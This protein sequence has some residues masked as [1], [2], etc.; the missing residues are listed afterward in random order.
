[1][2]PCIA[3]VGRPNV[4]K[5]TLFN[6]LIKR[7]KAIVADTPGVTRDRIFADARW[8]DREFLLVDTGGLVMTGENGLQI[9]IARQSRQAI[10]EA[11]M[12]IFLLDGKSGVTPDDARL[13]DYLR[14]TTKKVFWVVNKVESGADQVNSYD[15]YQLGM[16]KLFTVSAAHGLGIG[17][18]LDEI[19]AAL[20]SAPPAAADE[21]RQPLRV[22][23]IGKPNV[24][25]SSLLNLLLGEE[26][27]VT[28]GQP[29]TTVDAV[30]IPLQH[31][32]H[33]YL[34]F[35][36]AGL[37]RKSRVHDRVE[38]YGNV[39]T[40]RSIDYARIVLLMIDAAAGISDQDI[41]IASL[42]EEKNKA[43]I[44]LFNKIDLLAD[45]SFNRKAMMQ[46][47]ADRMPFISRP[48][49][50]KISVA[51][52]WGVG[53]ILPTIDE[54]AARLTYRESTGKLNRILAE[55]TTRH[56]HPLIHRHPL[57][58]YYI[59][60]IKGVPPTFVIFCNTVKGI[61]TSYVRYL[62]KKIQEYLDLGGVPI[63]IYF[64]KR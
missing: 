27:L 35:D 3:I 8:N 5:S 32:D 6:R 49:A 15:F 61:Q 48:W 17:E 62:K 33:R 25:K 52:K 51:R 57:K 64:R 16:E 58:F 56:Q 63:R 50:L 34:F 20:P 55:I 41:K 38:G 2:K 12:I 26:R 37:R 1:M 18:L 10:D 44:F 39:A 19:T 9:N 43:I 14:Q 59:T 22:A 4:G 30:E 13:A 21:A 11:D 40:M 47:L 45:K 7:K 46:L 53:R 31:G 24:G 28:S 36:T 23:V 42:A 29:G 54:L 60:Q